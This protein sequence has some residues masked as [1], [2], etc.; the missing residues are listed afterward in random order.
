MKK[1][2]ITLG[3]LMLMFCI[4]LDAVSLW[5]NDT[6]DMYSETKAHR[7]G[8]IVTIIINETSKATSKAASSTKGENNMTL[9]A[10]TGPFKFLPGTTGKV[11]NDFAG[12]ASTAR[13]GDLQAKITATI[14]KIFS[15][16][17]FLIK[18]TRRVTVNSEIQEIEISGIARPEDILQDNS[19]QSAYLADANVKYNGR[20]IVGDIQRPGLLNKLFQFLF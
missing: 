19:I 20:G 6:M 2:F 11:E 4:N 8:D 13:S 1:G 3:I 15:N 5:E 12:D 14:V 16:G 10:G 7:L 9:S 17:N 18:G